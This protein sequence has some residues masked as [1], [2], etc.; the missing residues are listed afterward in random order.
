MTSVSRFLTSVRVTA[1]ALGVLAAAAP[2]AVAHPA[3]PSGWNTDEAAPAT[4][5]QFVPDGNRLHAVAG[6]PV[7]A[8]Q[9]PPSGGES[10]QMVPGGSRYHRV[11]Q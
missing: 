1:L 7:Q 8:V 11:D 2:L 9:T 10:Y 4:A 3:Y 5:Y 6:A